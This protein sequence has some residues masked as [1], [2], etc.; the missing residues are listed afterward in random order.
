M[1]VGDEAQLPVSR[2]DRN[3]NAVFADVEFRPRVMLVHNVIAVRD[4]DAVL[5]DGGRVVRKEILYLRWDDRL[6]APP[7]QAEVLRRGLCDS[8][9]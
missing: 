8:A 4:I 7:A 1:H 5:H 2:A 6:Q 3:A 9:D